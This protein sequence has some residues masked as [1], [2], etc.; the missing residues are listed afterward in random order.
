M[1]IKAVIILILLLCSALIST[2]ITN[3]ASLNNV[4]IISIDALHPSALEKPT[5]ST[6]QRMMRSYAHTLNGLSTNPPKTLIA[7]TAMFTGLD[8]KESGNT[9][10]QWQPG[11][12]TIGKQTIF[13][14]AKTY[15]FSTGLFYAKQ[16]LGFLVNKALDAHNWS[17][18]FAIE[19]ASEFFKTP[20]RHFVFLHVSGLDE[21]G[22][23]YGWLS[24]E[25]LEELMYIDEFLAPV[26]A[27]V[28]KQR[29]YLIIITSDHAGHGK[30]HG[31]QNAEDFKLPFIIYSD[32]RNVNS[33]QDIQYNVLDLKGI[34][35]SLLLSP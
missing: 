16:K 12:S 7:H 1:L 4:L 15:G 28:E 14:T 20:G 32:V 13:D 23:E 18:E 24:S 9:D 10:N 19:H 34:L 30:I 8:P 11:Q 21:V 33:F 6:I 35:D 25:Y 26:I 2:G 29:N 22:P 27:Y 5:A 3:A 17:K 31:S